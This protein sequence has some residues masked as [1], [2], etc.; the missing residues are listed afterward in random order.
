[1]KSSVLSLLQISWFQTSTP[2][3]VRF[4]TVTKNAS[5]SLLGFSPVKNLVRD[6]IGK[7][8]L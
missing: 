3:E 4:V 1:M 5:S 7:N 2:N 6:L 8:T